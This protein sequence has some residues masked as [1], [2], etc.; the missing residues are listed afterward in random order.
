SENLRDSPRTPS[1]LPDVCKISA[2]LQRN[3]LQ[4][5][6]LCSRSHLRMASAPYARSDQASDIFRSI[7]PFIDLALQGTARFHFAKPLID[8][9][10]PRLV[11]RQEVGLLRL[12]EGRVGVSRA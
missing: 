3:H 10:L 7:H 6:N 11:L 1:S 12:R 5:I 4:R 9:A 2:S 8:A